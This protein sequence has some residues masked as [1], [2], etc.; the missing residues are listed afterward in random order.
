M[1]TAPTEINSLRDNNTLARA[2]HTE[3]AGGFQIHSAPDP[4]TQRLL[5]NLPQPSASAQIQR[6]VLAAG[7]GPS[8]RPVTQARG[9]REGGKPGGAEDETGQ[10]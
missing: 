10:E 1:A 9:W 3:E 2:R 4:R 8:T 6:V 7:G 5:S